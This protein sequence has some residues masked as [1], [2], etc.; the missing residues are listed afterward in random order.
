VKYEMLEL[1]AGD[2]VVAI[3]KPNGAT[4]AKMPNFH[5]DEHMLEK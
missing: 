2:N 3:G 5:R 1:H 4:I